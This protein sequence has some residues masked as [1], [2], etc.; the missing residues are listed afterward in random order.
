M[1][2]TTPTQS[3]NDSLPFSS[4]RTTMPSNRAAV[5]RMRAD[6]GRRFEFFTEELF[7][8]PAWDMLLCLYEAHLAQ[9]RTSIGALCDA[10]LVPAT[11]ALR[12][13]QKLVSVDLVTR[14]EDP[15]DHRRTWVA[16][17]NSGLISMQ[18]YFD[19]PGA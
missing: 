9:R 17:S 19:V 4:T 5:Q 14:T 7:S 2:E 11:T 3:A 1:F 6:R 18:R 12:W 15:L 16:L 10:S 8:D 13:L